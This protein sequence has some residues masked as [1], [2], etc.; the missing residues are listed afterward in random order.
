MNCNSSF[1]SS[2]APLVSPLQSTNNF[3]VL[4]MYCIMLKNP[5]S[6]F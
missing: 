5:I 2:L 1:Q 4:T 3:I 6:G